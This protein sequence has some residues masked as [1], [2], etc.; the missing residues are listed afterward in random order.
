MALADN[1]KARFDYEIIETIEAG[2]ELLGMEVKSIRTH[3]ATLDGAY[4][5]IRGGEA[6][7]M[8]MS[9]PPYQPTN[10]PKEYDPLRI[11]RLLLTKKEIRKLADIEAGKGLTIVPIKVYNK[12]KKV[13]IAIG[14][15]RG[16]KTFDKRESIKKRETDRESRRTLKYE[17]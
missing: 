8:Q 11:R 9:V 12:G 6:Y 17:E 5:T 10:S 2:I 1:K 14:I 4:V 13:K 3:G 16:K 15:A 7:M